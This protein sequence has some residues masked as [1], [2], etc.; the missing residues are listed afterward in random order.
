[1][2]HPILTEYGNMMAALLSD[3]PDA[4]R[5]LS[6]SRQFNDAVVDSTSLDGDL[7][8]RILE[9]LVA[10]FYS[11]P[12]RFAPI[13]FSAIDFVRLRGPGLEA[14]IDPLLAFYDQVASLAAAYP[15]VRKQVELSGLTSDSVS[16]DDLLARDHPGE[17]YSWHVIP[18]LTHTVANIA[19]WSAPFRQQAANLK[20]VQAL[21]SLPSSQDFDAESRSSEVR[22]SI[23]ALSR[24]LAQVVICQDR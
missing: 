14:I 16:L 13:L 10:S 2:G 3:P 23:E 15:A 20:G 19:P 1:M 4:E 17:F 21:V 8:R 6:R 12:L 7:S 24:A 22:S 18:W 9:D 5:V 11:V